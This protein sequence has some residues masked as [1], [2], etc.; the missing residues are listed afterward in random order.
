MPGTIL[1]QLSTTPQPDN[2]TITAGNS[3]L[4]SIAIGTDN[5]AV[6][7]AVAAMGQS[8]GYRFT[9]GATGNQ[10]TTYLDLDAPVSVLSIRIPFRISATPSASLTFLRGYT[11]T[12][13]SDISWSLQVTT[14]MRINFG[15]QNGPT[16]STGSGTTERL[17]AGTDYV[18]QLQ[19]D[20]DAELFSLSTY[21]R[22]SP[23]P[24]NT[25]S[26]ALTSSMAAQHAVRLG[27]NSSS[28]LV[29]GYIDT[30]SA[31]ALGEGDLLARHDV[32]NFAP[33][34][35]VT[36]S[37]TTLHPGE[38]ATLTAT[39]TDS[40][41]TITSIN[42]TAS[43]GTLGGSGSTRTITAP[44]LLND[45][46]STVTVVATDNGGATTTRFIILTFKASMHKLY[47]ADGW[48]PLIAKVKQ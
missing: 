43:A 9:Q 13:H 47:T 16:T 29:S 3:G 39:A 41:G 12:A 44:P 19:I 7:L 33:S 35:S 24:I 10:I 37:Q 27:I 45:L 5:S 34:L 38:S 46:T 22:G 28:A 6:F 18:I 30:N 1:K 8:A 42:W 23:D 36:A 14:T 4:S 31:F 25:M 17:V 21:E 2:T 48:V 20:T 26:G 40:D 11:N 15:E 32:A